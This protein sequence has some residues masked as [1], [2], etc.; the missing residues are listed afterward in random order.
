M[1]EHRD[2]V[3]KLKVSASKGV[4]KLLDY[5]ESPDYLYLCLE[6]HITFK[7]SLIKR[8]IE[9]GD[10]MTILPPLSLNE[11]ICSQVHNAEGKTVHKFRE[12]RA[13][14]ISYQLVQTISKLHEKGLIIRDLDVSNIYLTQNSDLGIIRI[15]DLQN[16]LIMGPKQ[17]TN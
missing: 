14:D 9:K 13:V 12:E 17:K 1:E 11:Y 8:V 3:Y 7:K 15:S 10:F 5:F 2:E 6:R 4:I 16:A